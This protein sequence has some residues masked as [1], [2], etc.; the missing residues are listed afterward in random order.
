[1]GYTRTADLRTLNPQ[2]LT[3]RKIA[4]IAV[5]LSLLFV[6]QLQAGKNSVIELAGHTGVIQ[7]VGFSPLGQ[8]VVTVDDH[9]VRIWNSK[10]GKQ[11]R[12]LAWCV[13]MDPALSSNGK[14]YV[15]LENNA[16]Q[17]WNARTG[18][19]IRTLKWCTHEEQIETV[20]LSPGGRRM[21]VV[22]T[23]NTVQVW[24]ART[25]RVTRGISGLP[26]HIESAAVS[27]LGKRVV[28]VRGCTVQIWTLP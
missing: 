10:T 21:A 27:P 6:A 25:G 12:V 1:M 26:G 2:T 15:T 24:N 28:V 22:D 5:C 11:I 3:M 18:K 14:R 13:E 17:I 20:A 4:C 9:F 7:Y 19:L 23:G 16:V 8:R